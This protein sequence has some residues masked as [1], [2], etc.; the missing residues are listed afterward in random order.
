MLASGMGCL[1]LFLEK[2]DPVEYD[3]DSAL[4]QE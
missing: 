2:T 4:A 3:R 1:F